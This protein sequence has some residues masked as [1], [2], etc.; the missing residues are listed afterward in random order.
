M[1]PYAIALLLLLSTSL[2]AA[3]HV[4]TSVNTSEEIYGVGDVVSDM[5]WK[6]DQNQ[7]VCLNDFKGV[8]VL[9]YNAGW[10]GPCNDEF[11]EIS[12]RVKEF[13]GKAVTFISLSGAGYSSGSQPNQSFLQSWRNRHSIPSSVVVA[14]S[15]RDY[16]QSFGHSAI[17]NVAVIDPG[18]KLTFTETAPGVD[19]TFEEVRKALMEF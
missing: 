3:R 7:Q 11:D 8:R 19:A 16:G 18:G 1:K 10:C 13:D 12:P 17:P 2:M 5:C 6:N 4:V 15:P 14:G 9:L